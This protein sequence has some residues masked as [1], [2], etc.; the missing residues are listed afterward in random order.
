MG[1]KLSYPTVFFVAA[2]QCAQ[3]SWDGSSGVTGG[4]DGVVANWD[5]IKCTQTNTFSGHSDAVLCLHVGQR[6][7]AT[8]SMDG[9]IKVGNTNAPPLIVPSVGYLSFGPI[10]KDI[11]FFGDLCVR[12]KAWC[13]A[14]Q[15]FEHMHNTL[16]HR[17]KT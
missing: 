12:K 2:V 13:A 9:L 15:A 5:V 6:F 4:R 17:V 10:E 3:L 14:S 1:P 16:S 11:M 7:I 8:G